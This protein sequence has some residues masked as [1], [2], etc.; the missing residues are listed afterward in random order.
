MNV[1]SQLDSWPA[2]KRMK[3]RPIEDPAEHESWMLIDTE[4]SRR[5]HTL[6]AAVAVGH[7][8]WNSVYKQV[9][10]GAAIHMEVCQ[11]LSDL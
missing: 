2:H 11:T 5:D 8:R 7:L 10:V 6:H 4:V 9:S 1:D 3:D